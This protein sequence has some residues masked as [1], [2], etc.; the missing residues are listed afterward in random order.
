MFVTRPSQI[1]KE[2][3]AEMEG[4]LCHCADQGRGKGKEVVWV[5]EPLLHFQTPFLSFS[6]LKP[7]HPFIC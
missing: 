7:K 2:K 5:E 6:R 1:L 3:V 4:H